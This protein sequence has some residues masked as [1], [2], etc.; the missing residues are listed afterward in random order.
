VASR[1]T[2]SNPVTAKPPLSVSF[3]NFWGGFAARDF[4]FAR[5]LGDVFDV[6]IDAVGRDVQ[7]SSVFGEETLPQVAGCRPLRVWFTGECMEPRGQFFDLYFGFR[8]Q[9]AQL[10]KRWHRY[11]LWIT[12]ID[13]WDPASP[14]HISRLTAPRHWRERPRFCNFIYS[15]PTSIRAEF[16]LRLNEARPVDSL[17]GVLNNHGRRLASGPRAKMKALSEYTFTI[18]FENQLSPGYVTEKL[19]EPLMAGSV[20]VYWG[21]P[22]AKTDFNPGAFLFAEDFHGFAELVEHVTR[23]ANSGGDDLVRLATAAPLRP[24][25]IPYEHTPRFFVDRIAEILSGSAEPPLPDRF[26][27]IRLSPP[28]P[29]ATQKL[30]R[31]ARSSAGRALRRLGLTQDRNPGPP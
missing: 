23:L 9:T 30:V 14:Y 20:P 11:P 26:R 19:L 10:G 6:T 25:G 8:P 3:H 16:F 17:G 29:T 27:S 31:K 1:D 4:M 13:W 18:A 28:L 22:E 24:G 12:Y 7:F 2:W 15:N 21:P 5:A